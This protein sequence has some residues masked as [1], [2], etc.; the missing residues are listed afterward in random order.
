MSLKAKF[1]LFI[2]FIHSIQIALAIVL[3]DVDKLL[4]IVCELLIVVSLIISFGLYDSFLRPH[5][6]LNSGIESL[7]DQ[8]FSIKI[9]NV[10]Q[11]ELD[12][13]IDVFNSM[14]DQLKME[15]MQLT[16]RNFFL[17]KLVNSSSSGILIL[18]FENKI[19]ALNSAC[20]A[21][22]G[23]AESQLKG[24]ALEDVAHPIA[25][26]LAK[27]EIRES[28]VLQVNGMRKYKCT[29]LSFKEK[30]A[31]RIFFHLDEL[32]SELIRAERSSYEKVIRIMAHEVNNTIGAVNSIINTTLR[33]DNQIKE[34]AS[35]Q[36]VDALGS[37]HQRN[38]QLNE[39]MKN[40]ADVV[41]L[42]LPVKE[43][44]DIRQLL[45]R[46]GL[47]YHQQFNERNIEWQLKMPVFPMMLSIDT[48]Q[49]ETVLLN[50]IKNAI[51]AIGTDGKINVVL[52]DA[53]LQ[54]Q[55]NGEPISTEAQQQLFEAF[56]TT[57]ANG[58]GIGLTLTKEILMNHGFDFSLFTNE[59]RLT[60]F[61]VNFG[62]KKD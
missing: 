18:D 9:R 61:R 11:K 41:K 13:L 47:L 29:K 23:A 2:L 60:I 3:Y 22:F 44:V 7:K 25:K 36:L 8:D 52:D 20:Q 37:A 39:F 34:I 6:L 21:I 51:E 12:Q 28:Q 14:L 45:Q 49:I 38:A 15:R 19:A 1:I 54:I 26:M 59:E 50:V 10:G 17:D 24:I 46:I 56:Y 48:N 62:T 58:Q 42:P 30:G 33:F 32:T 27:M 16:E 40:Y 5:R 31:D 4:F 53:S 35:P 55:N 57:K 43:S